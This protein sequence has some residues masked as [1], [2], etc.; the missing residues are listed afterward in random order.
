MDPFLVVFAIGVGF[1][2]GRISKQS[3]G[4]EQLSAFKA[5]VANFTLSQELRLQGKMSDENFT[6]ALKRFHSACQE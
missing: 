6:E 1:A 3:D 5:D 4:N 2:I